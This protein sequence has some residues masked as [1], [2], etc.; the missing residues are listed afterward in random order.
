MNFPLPL[1]E[2]DWIRLKTK[3]RD[4]QVHLQ[5]LESVLGLQDWFIGSED[6]LKRLIDTYQGN[7][8]LEWWKRIMTPVSSKNGGCGSPGTDSI[9]GWFVQD[10]LGLKQTIPW[11][12]GIRRNTEER[13]CGNYWC[14]T[15][16][17]SSRQCLATDLEDIPSGLNTVPL[18][19]KDYTTGHEE[20]TDLVAGVTGFKVERN[21]QSVPGYGDYH[22][23]QTVH[24]WGLL[25][26]PD[27]RY[28]PKTASEIT[29]NKAE[30]FNSN[31]YDTVFDSPNNRERAGTV[32]PGDEVFG[33]SNNGWVGLPG[34]QPT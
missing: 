18:T 31:N 26:K 25:V 2:N 19:I 30:T 13:V 14:N 33:P 1:T 4:L 28:L 15:Q 34:F 23:A 8:D 22:V 9:G 27:S 7:P 6:V 12:H 10:F 5:P 3:L 16:P 20:Q 17:G 21:A 24:G 32:N 11:Y 29:Q